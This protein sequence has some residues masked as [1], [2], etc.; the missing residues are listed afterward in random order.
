MHYGKVFE[1][2]TKSIDI[3]CSQQN[4]QENTKTMAQIYHD[5]LVLEMKKLEKLEK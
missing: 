3:I 5:Q 1:L 2:L 4:H